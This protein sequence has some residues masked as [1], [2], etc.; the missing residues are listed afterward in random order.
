M[1]DDDLIPTAEDIGKVTDYV[2]SYTCK[3]NETWIQEREFNKNIALCQKENIGDKSDLKSLARK[4]LNNSMKTRLI[5]K[6]EAIFQSLEFPLWESTETPLRVSLSNLHKL[7]SSMEKKKPNLIEKY[8][9]RDSQFENH[10]LYNFITETEN[11][12]VGKTIFPNFT[13]CHTQVTYPPTIL[14][15]VTMLTI[16]KPW[17]NKNDLKVNKD[18]LGKYVSWIESGNAPTVLQIDHS[19]AK[20]R[21]KQGRQNHEIISQKDTTN[22][23]EIL[24]EAP[25]DLKETILLASTN[26]TDDNDEDYHFDFGL[27]HK[28][29][30]E[31][32]EQQYQELDPQNWLKN[33]IDEH[34]ENEEFRLKK[35]LNSI[36]DKD[37]NL[38]ELYPDQQKIAIEVLSKV[39]EWYE[40]FETGNSQDN[41]KKVSIHEIREF[42]SSQILTNF[43]NN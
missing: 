23:D 3:G 43:V 18:T 9:K 8:M 27:D 13:G 14:E 42:S 22:I 10:T 34:D 35:Q 38:S 36:A 29:H 4:M 17:R 1:E 41:E 33:T 7:K 16:H 24:R 6:Q 5:S 12:F 15:A 31:T 39:K 26:Q 37:C 30:D 11:I 19:R 25:D 2:V 28:W 21:W 40:L 20:Q 32:V